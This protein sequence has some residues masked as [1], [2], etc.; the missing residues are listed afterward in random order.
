VFKDYWLAILPAYLF[1][2]VLSLLAERFLTPRPVL[3][4]QRPAWTLGV[5]V[6][7]WTLMFGLEVALFRRPYFGATNVLAIQAL[8]ILVS[9]AKYQALREPFI[10]Q[11]FEYF[12]DAVKH[13]RLYLPFFGLTRALVASAGYAL[14]LWVGLSWE[15]SMAGIAISNP[16]NS[17]T[18][19]VLFTLSIVAAGFAAALLAG[20][21]SMEVFNPAENLKQLGLAATLW[22]YGRAERQ[23]TSTI[24]QGAPFARMAFPAILPKS[25]PDMVVIQSESFFDARHTYSQLREDILSNFDRLKAESVQYGA[26]NVTAR[27]ANTVRTEFSFL[28]G[29]AAADLGIHQYNPYRRLA[30]QSFPTLPSHLKTLGYRTVCVHPY[31]RSF[32]RRNTVMPL[33]GFDQFI[34]IEA[35]QDAVRD[36]PYVGDQALGK[37]VLGLLGG[38]EGKPLYVHVIT[39]ENHGP[40]H[41][42]TVTEAD[43]EALLRMPIPPGCEDLVAYA[44]H[45]RNA[46]F[47]LGGLAQGL[48]DRARMTALCLYGDHVPIMP[49]VYSKLGAP[50]GET[51]YILWRSDG[52]GL[53]RDQVCDISDLAFAYLRVAGLMAP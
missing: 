49:A 52:P 16:W 28:S 36:G 35:F 37:H 11:D 14:A 29:M 6:G 30:Q 33:L 47:M 43:S 20:R 51:N 8:I 7:I 45:L 23:A 4:W 34:G 10:F 48:K 46:D 26:L 42:E 25:L 17:A 12:L 13:P 22:V 2:L 53:A 3:P 19:F 32:Y 27:G 15:P 31:H 21:R 44:R 39:M 5:H 18:A 9:N 24:R 38:G 50:S 41:W 1:G 40:L